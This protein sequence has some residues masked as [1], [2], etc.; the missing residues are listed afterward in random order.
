MPGNTELTP[1]NQNEISL[2][3]GALTTKRLIEGISR[4][5]KAFPSLPID[6]YDILTD[7]L[8]ANGFSDA[9]FA[10]AV[11][12]VIDSC[13]Y[14]TPTVADFISFDKRVKCFSYFEIVKMVDAGDIDAFKRHQRIVLKD[15]P[16]AV[17]IHVNDIAKYNIKSFE[18]KPNEKTT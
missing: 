9:R 10:D 13:H 17:W 3:S 16:D 15:Q 2:Y 1:V 12:H 7:R 6:F 5:K 4:T 11:N 14:P 8:E 18:P